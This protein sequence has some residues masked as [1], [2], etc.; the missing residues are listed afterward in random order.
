MTTGQVS[1]ERRG[2]VLLIGLDRAAKR[3]AFDLP[4]WDGLCRAYGELQRDPD[5][6]VGVLHAHGDHFTGGLDLP[7]WAPVF[8][9]GRWHIPDGGVDPLGLTG[10]RLTKPIVAA[11]Q[12]ICLTIGIELLLATDVRIAA[13]STRFAQIEIKRGIY[14]VGGA[15]LRFPRE[16]GWANAMRWLLTGDELGA[17]E[18]LRI[19]LVQEVVEHGQQLDR[20]V[21]LAEVIAAQAP[22]GVYATLAS[23]RA[24]LPETE[25]AAATRL[26]P[27]LQPLLASEDMQEGLRAFVARQPGAF[28]GR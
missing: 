22:L 2:H 26:M 13:A 12:G 8:A 15:T 18:A 17:A 27:D 24:A 25:A 4:L 16:V 11:T 7:Q 3:N 23:S 19:G 21:A 1:L 14:P 6:R 10:P 9:S 20:A 5:L 28:K